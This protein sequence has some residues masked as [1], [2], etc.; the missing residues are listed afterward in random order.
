[1]LGEARYQR[2]EGDAAYV[3]WR[4]AVSLL[5]SDGDADPALMATACGRLALL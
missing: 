4:E 1:M 5:E 3:A 2:A